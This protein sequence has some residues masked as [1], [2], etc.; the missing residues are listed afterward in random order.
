MQTLVPM[1]VSGP[2]LIEQDRQVLWRQTTL[3]S[4]DLDDSLVEISKS[5]NRFYV[6]AYNSGSLKYQVIDMFRMIGRKLMFAC[7]QLFTKLI[8]LLEYKFGKLVIRDFETLLQQQSSTW[9]KNP[10]IVR[11][12]INDRSVLDSRGGGSNTIRQQQNTQ[13][14]RVGNKVGHSLDVS[15]RRLANDSE[16]TINSSR[17]HH[18]PSKLTLNEYE[19]NAQV[20][21][22]RASQMNC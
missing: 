2:K 6:V 21:S 1:Q 16:M 4:D 9:K 11:S 5:K 13:L 10:S 8:S 7:D 17:R 3:L 12:H 22:P 15:S 14:R 18:A 20:I 19:F